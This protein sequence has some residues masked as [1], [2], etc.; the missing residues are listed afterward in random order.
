MKKRICE[1]IKHDRDRNKNIFSLYWRYCVDVDR[2]SKN[3]RFNNNVHSAGYYVTIK[4]IGNSQPSLKRVAAFGKN[5]RGY[6]G[7]IVL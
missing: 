3:N 4:K 6:G 1:A 7:L 5:S 2:L